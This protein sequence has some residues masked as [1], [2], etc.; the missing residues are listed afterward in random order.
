[1]YSAANDIGDEAPTAASRLAMV[2]YRDL[3]VLVIASPEIGNRPESH[4]AERKTRHLSDVMSESPSA[5]EA[6]LNREPGRSIRRHA[7]ASS[8]RCS[9]MGGT[10]FLVAR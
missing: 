2:R 7:F 8:L 10:T 6:P 9:A 1:M 5:I 3:D 4:A